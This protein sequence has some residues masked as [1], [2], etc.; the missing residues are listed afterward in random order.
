MNH[1]WLKSVRKGLGFTQAVMADEMGVPLRTYEDLECGKSGLR[2]VHMNAVG[3]AVL[4]NTHN[5]PPVFAG[6]SRVLAA[7]AIL[8]LA[9]EGG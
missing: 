6:G 9:N 7:D 5:L 8:R 1:K 4:M 3:F 2:T